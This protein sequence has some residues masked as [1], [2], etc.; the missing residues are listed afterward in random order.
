[1]TDLTFQTPE[2]ARAWDM[3]VAGVLS[4]P[5]CYDAA[6]IAD[7]LILERRKRMAP[8]DSKPEREWIPHK[9]G[10]PMPCDRETMVEVRMGTQNYQSPSTV[11]APAWELNWTF[12]NDLMSDRSSYHITAWRPAQ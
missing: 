5:S 4:C 8:A 10:H 2:E 9:P 7:D 11:T 3:Y 12:I 1:M 6:T